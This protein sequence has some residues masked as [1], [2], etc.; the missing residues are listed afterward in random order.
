MQLQAYYFYEAHVVRASYSRSDGSILAIWFLPHSQTLFAGIQ[1][2]I[3]TSDTWLQSVYVELYTFHS[4]ISRDSWTHITPD[5]WVGKENV[6]QCESG[7]TAAYPR[8][9]YFFPEWLT[10]LASESGEY[11]IQ[12]LSLLFCIINACAPMVSK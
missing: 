8:I 11:S 6:S 12:L 10:T 3:I 5:I 4:G 1:T 9:L 2:C 7:C